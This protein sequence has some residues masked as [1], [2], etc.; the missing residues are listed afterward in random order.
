MN[1]SP[2]APT[3]MELVNGIDGHHEIALTLSQLAEV[4]DG[5][6]GYQHHCI[7]LMNVIETELRAAAA[8]MTALVEKIRDYLDEG[9]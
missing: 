3:T 4:I 8:S 7:I 2:T 1:T 9:E 5:S 6:I